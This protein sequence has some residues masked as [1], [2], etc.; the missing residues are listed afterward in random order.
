MVAVKS[1]EPSPRTT[2]AAAA[3]TTPSTP[4]NAAGYA[5]MEPEGVW[6]VVSAH[7]REKGLVRQQLDS[8]NEFIGS[9]CQ[10]IVDEMPDI[11][12]RPEPQH[13]PG[14]AAPAAGTKIVISF[15]QL[16]TSKPSFT[17]SDGKATVL[18]PNEARLRNLSYSAALYVEVTRVDVEVEAASGEERAFRHEP[19]NLFLGRIPM[20]LRA[21]YCQLH[22]LSEYQLQNLGEC[23]YD[24]GGYFVI[25]GS[26]KVLIAQERMGNN[27][28][29]VFR[30]SGNSAYS[31]V[32]ECRS[33]LDR[34]NKPART[35]QVKITRGGGVKGQSGQCVMVTLP[36]IRAD[37]P[38]AIVFRALGIES[39]RE[40]MERVVHDP[41]DEEMQTLLM[42]S[43]DMGSVITDQNVALDFIG[44]RGNAV[45]VT[46]ERRIRYAREVLQLEYLPHIGIGAYEP[47]KA[48]FLGYMT[49]RLL[50]TVLGRRTE[51]DR[52]HYGIKRLD[53]AGPLL[54]GLFR[55][56]F[57]KV[58]R[59]ARLILQ[60]QL[61][62]G[63]ELNLALAI[64]SR[65][66]TDNLKYAIATGNWRADRNAAVRT[67][68]SQVL[69]RLTFA[70]SLS[71]LRRLN[72]PI[73]REGKLA[74]PRQLH[75][76]QW[77]M[78]C[79]AETPEGQACGLVKNLALMAYISVGTP[80]AD[81]LEM[82]YNFE[83]EPL[84]EV[85]PAQV[86]RSTK[87][88]LNGAWV[89]I[90]PRPEELVSTLR[91][92]R[93]SNEIADEVSIVLD[94]GQRELRIGTD[95]GRVCRPLFIVEP[96]TGALRI[97]QHHV[98]LL[99]D[100]ETTGYTFT[101][102]VN[103]GLVEYLDVNEEETVMIAM[104]LEHL[105]TAGRHAMYT[106]MEIHPSM[107]LG[108]CASIIPF[109]DHNQSPRNTYQAAMGKQ[110]MGMYITNYNMRMD[111]LA[112]LLYYPQ[113][114]LVTTRIME[115]LQFR[116]L[117][118]GINAVVAIAC[119]SGYNQE[120]SLIMSQAAVD[121][122]FFRSLYLKTVKE[123]EQ[124][125]LL[126]QQELIERP[127]P[128]TTMG[129]KPMGA[130]DKLEQDGIVGVGERVRGGDVLI[131]KTAPLGVGRTGDGADTVAVAG[132]R[133]R[134]DCSLVMKRTEQG[135]TDKV[136]VCTGESGTRMVKIRIRTELVPQVGDKFASRHGQKGTIGLCMPEEDL[137]FDA[138]GVKPDI[139]MNPHAVPSRMTIAH[140]IEALLGKV[141]ALSG[142][143]GDATAFTPVT[144]DAIG[145]QL[146][147]YGFDPRGWT[148]LCNGQSGQ[149]MQAAIFMG[150]NYY[151]RLRHVVFQKLGARARG[152]VQVLTRQPVEG[153][154]R[155]GGLRI[156]EMEKDVFIAYGA[157]AV[158]KERMCDV[159]DR[160]VVHVCDLCGLIAIADTKRQTFECRACKNKTQVSAVE[161]PYA[162]KLLFQE[163]Q[164]M[165]IVPRMVLQH[166]GE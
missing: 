4:S 154:S 152:A 108:V 106:H 156:G 27:C 121:R 6:E 45:G 84:Y 132:A 151:Q 7:F 34:G 160:Y 130:Y 91:L 76:T 82:L 87:V 66:I 105:A 54:T 29:Y 16:S 148:Q 59:E 53:L 95:A 110:A 61:D 52:D 37:I 12:L 25:N 35:T 131:G 58:V 9:A 40:I 83:M 164:A 60:R 144:V 48:W 36:Y 17:E 162:C 113:K 117:P 99:R 86:Y 18:F 79:P 39:D 127:D 123:E 22:G 62:S 137:P 67:G 147:Q 119:Y 70:A 101:H 38:L 158:L 135:V 73:G 98:E 102:L 140:L 72:S 159:S 80:V 26:E 55:Q 2:T 157:S 33:V 138:D 21:D 74:K 109:P 129:M 20:M 166:S 30:R 111:S 126:G 8:F 44:K 23:P 89:G 32:A 56:L 14:Q 142:A 125:K 100:Y 115:H 19:R 143:E 63:K 41:R 139:I 81:I 146:V 65:T 71:H 90:H 28:V 150:I 149:P 88:F 94:V 161:M 145:A 107:V 42:P 49:H 43:L 96:K 120:D 133:T 46:R 24:Q 50:A 69:N 136:M 165:A 47:A 78:I 75:N 1:E 134:K 15:G 122:G 5:P 163:L 31:H 13:V 118:A 155:G 68:V 114:P 124:K 97:R 10:T 51:D 128:A 153:K 64:K 3:A 141:C 85:S 112:H 104:D 57:Q 116:A 92:L 11:V 103:E 77:G 93:R